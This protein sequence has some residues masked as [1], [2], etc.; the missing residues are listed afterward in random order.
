MSLPFCNALDNSVS[1]IQP[2]VDLCSACVTACGVA[3]ILQALM[4]SEKSVLLY[5]G[6]LTAVLW[7][8]HVLFHTGIYES[9]R[10]RCLGSMSREFLSYEFP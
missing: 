9:A 10:S 3:E 5:F 4:S 6:I 1:R 7:V 8:D 2:L